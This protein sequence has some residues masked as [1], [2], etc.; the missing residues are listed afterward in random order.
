[1]EGG[2]PVQSFVFAHVFSSENPG[3]IEDFYDVEKKLLGEGSYG[4]VS[5]G[6]SKSTGAVRAIKAISRNKVTDEKKFYAEND[7][8]K[9]MDHPNI[10]KLCEVFKDAKKYYL[11]MELCTGG[12]LFDRIID[13]AEQSGVEGIAFGESQAAEYMKQI[14]G[15]IFYMHS[16]DFVHRDIKPENFLM[17]T[18]QADADI[19][20]ID[21]GL[22]MHNPEKKQMKT[23]AGTPYYVA[24]EVLAGAY[25]EKCDIWSCG[26]IAYILLCGYPPFFGDADK[27][28]LNMVKKGKFDFPSPDWDDR[29]NASKDFIRKM[30]TMKIEDRPSAEDCLNL[31]WLT[32]K[33][34]KT[35]AIVT[36]DQVSFD[37]L[38]SFHKM[39]KLKK[40][41]VTALAQE[42]DSKDIR[43][44]KKMFKDIDQNGDGMLEVE[45]IQKLVVQVQKSGNKSFDP[46]Q[47]QMLLTKL[48]TDKSGKV[49]WSEFL[50]SMTDRKLYLT[51]EAMWRAF[52]KFDL[53]GDGMITKKE[54]AKVLGDGD[55]LAT[56]REKDVAEMIKDGDLNG[57]GEIS[58]DEFKKLMMTEE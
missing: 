54:L 33:G 39:S 1:M 53:D 50:A 2:P 10:V 25:T 6:K 58:F 19:K 38:R 8:H 31:E 56:V 20:V 41:A 11:V 52:R 37:K 36:F 27:D 12:E 40:M 14:M 44:L 42:L 28:I 5:K 46:E 57:D 13:M 29:S 51:E 45:E 16:N 23:K 35:D 18:K 48:D 17:E 4:N 34:G 7:I 21:F 26:V 43:D 32:G 22:A 15:A 55:D 9:K 24:P 3:K 30:L 47:L 49:D